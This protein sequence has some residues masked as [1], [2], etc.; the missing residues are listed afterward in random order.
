MLPFETLVVQDFIGVLHFLRGRDNYA[1]F[2]RDFSVISYRIHGRSV[3]SVGENRVEVG[4]GDF[5]YIP[6]RLAYRQ[7]ND[8]QEE[9]IALHFRASGE[10]GAG[11]TRLRPRDGERCVALLHRM[12][13][14][15]N[16][17]GADHRPR[18]LGL[19][20]ALLAELSLPEEAGEDDAIRKAEKTIARR[21]SDPNFSVAD[22]A[23]AAGMSECGFRRAFAR[24]LGTS[25]QKY[26][27]RL[28]LAHAEALLQMGYLP[29]GEV[30]RRCGFA[31]PKY[32]TRVWRTAY[33]TLPSA[34]RG[35]R[36]ALTAS[37][38]GPRPPTASDREE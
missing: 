29:V 30:A 14:A 32:F 13:D 6:A 21:F 26:L 20:Y 36:Y 38:D 27:T 9:V 4:E 24:R 17:L 2:P 7:K 16:A 37:S 15:W 5:L 35:R 19:L 18:L 31:D 8:A 12:T 28:R 3:F 22:M 23:A 10:E 25:P 1:T 11:M 33:G 34:V